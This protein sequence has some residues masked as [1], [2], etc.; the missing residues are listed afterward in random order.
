M[1]YVFIKGLKQLLIDPKLIEYRSNKRLIEISFKRMAQGH[2]GKPG[3]RIFPFCGSCIE[4]SRR[5]YHHF[6]DLIEISCIENLK[7]VSPR[8][9][10]LL[11]MSNTDTKIC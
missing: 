8:E 9:K 6:C 11:A 3:P 7:G 1:S 2:T 5:L 4:D 10:F